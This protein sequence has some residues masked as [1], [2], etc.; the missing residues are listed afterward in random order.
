M[1]WLTERW[2]LHVLGSLRAGFDPGRNAVWIL[3]QLDRGEWV[4][5]GI[6]HGR[7]RADLSAR[8]DGRRNG[9]VIIADNDDVVIEKELVLLGN[10]HH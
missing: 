10:E 1:A 3:L 6:C 2:R 7:Q 4:C 5:D 9:A 8:L